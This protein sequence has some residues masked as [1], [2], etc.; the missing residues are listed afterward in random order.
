M[1]DTLTTNIKITNQTEG[2]NA[3]SWGTICDD[4]FE[5]IDDKFGDVT[6]ISTTGGTTTLTDTQEI[7]NAIVVTGTLVSN[8]EIVFSGRGGTWA[9]KNFTTGPYTVICKVSGQPGTEITQGTKVS[10][11]C[12]GTDIETAGG[13][14][15]ATEIPT[16]SV[17]P[18]LS[19]TTPSGWIR[20][21]GRTLGNAASGSSERA[22]A[23]TEA[24][25][26]LLW[27]SFPSL[28]IFDSA[29][30]ATTRGANGAADYA[31]NKRLTL[32]DLRGRSL[33]G[34]DDMGNTAAGRLGSI[35]TSATTNGATGGTE[36]VVL[37]EANL[38]AHT[39]TGPS[40]THTFSATSG[41]ESADHTHT[42]SGTTS[43]NGDHAH[44]YAAPTFTVSAVNNVTSVATGTIAASTST[45]GAHAHTWSGTSS[46][47]SA[48]HTHSVSGTT[49]ASG[50]GN[51][52]SAGS[53]AAHSNMPP[54]WLITFLIKL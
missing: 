31:A 36:T 35:I 41:T 19:T 26:V 15:N 7:V 34:L 13:P 27:D 28:T 24:L 48:N 29:G 12:N 25:Y 54:A 17:M 8:S 42:V 10:V 33:F 23:D 5:R 21:N 4:N 38:A 44:T 18:Y 6:A 37:T 16:G 51:T 9:V 30:T 14:S 50:T 40:H 11:F 2:G 39:H 3:N 46:G 1:A 43:S 47:R 52:G 49:G 45:N 53:G 20:A 32:P 22:N